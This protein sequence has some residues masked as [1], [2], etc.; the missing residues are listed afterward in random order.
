MVNQ[1]RQGDRIEVILAVSGG[2]DSIY[3]LNL[4]RQKVRGLLVAHYNHG[5]RGRE[6]E[7][8]QRFLARLCKDW[9]LSMEVG[10]VQPKVTVF[11]PTGRKGRVPPRFEK[12]A[13]ETRY[14]FLKDLL[15]RHKAQKILVAHT[16]DDQVE[17]VL[18]RILEGAGIAGLKGIP[19]STD[20]GV[21]RPLLDTWR[22]EILEY[23][24]KHKIPYRIDKSNLDTRFERNW[25][26]HVL[27][28]LLEKRYGNSVKKRIYAL[29]ERFRELDV[30][31]E[32]TAHKWLD[33]NNIYYAKSHKSGLP[34]G[35]DGKE[36]IPI[37]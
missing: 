2:P 36:A 25:I 3:L 32:Q 7:A 31:I 21:E 19:R 20:D 34:P 17:T 33:S 6:S 37:P 26:R 10:K 35:R 8:D 29:G 16:A 1:G 13:R 14:A 30:F 27:I 23:L 22:E 11:P 4:S 15:V 5:A 12:K 24:K 18:M 9:G 28:P